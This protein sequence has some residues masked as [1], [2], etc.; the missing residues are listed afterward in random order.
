MPSQDFLRFENLTESVPTAKTL[1]RA[2]YRHYLKFVGLP[3]L[4]LIL[5][6]AIASLVILILLLKDIL[7]I[8]VGKMILLLE[9]AL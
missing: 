9:L 7:V 5:I 2:L 3:F 6:G 8:F 1:H 4:G